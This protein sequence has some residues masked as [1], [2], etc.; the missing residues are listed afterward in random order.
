MQQSP[1][2]GELA[3]ALAAAQADMKAPN[4][5]KTATIPGKEGR[6]GYSYKY[7]DLADVIE[8]YR[9]CLSKHGLALA[10]PILWQDNHMLLR[11]VLMHS[12]GEWIDSMYPVPS[13]QRP[14]D[15]GSALTYARRYA[16]SALLGIAAEEDDDGQ[17]A[18]DAEPARRARK[19][20]EPPPAPAPAA[21]PSVHGLTDADIEDISPL[22]KRV[23]LAKHGDLKPLLQTI[24]G[25]DTLR[26]LDRRWLPDLKSALESKAKDSVQRDVDEIFPREAAR[27]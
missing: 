17:R 12:S 22:A 7:A 25:V 27:G 2:I 13:S 8:S 20:P 21:A 3:K 14:Q 1:T 15:T 23:G 5:A 18:Q 26:A 9:T 10:Q 24:G 11:T 4:K 6:S 19:A 16:A